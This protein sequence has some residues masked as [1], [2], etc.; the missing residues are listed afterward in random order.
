MHKGEIM[1]V[2]LIMAFLA[3]SNGVMGMECIHKEQYVDYK[4]D[5]HKEF[6]NVSVR[7]AVNA[8]N[9]YPYKEQLEKAQTLSQPTFPTISF[10]CAEDGSVI[11][12]WSLVPGQFEVFHQTSKSKKITIETDNKKY[13]EHLIELYFSGE[14]QSLEKEMSED[15]TA[16]I[17]TSFWQK[18]MSVF[19]KN[20]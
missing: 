18:I 11:A 12:I 3:I 15:K 16:T 1:K 20:A 6:G 14:R 13:I 2:I 5:Q 4:W 8:F 19:K 7:E 10:E 9:A 17:V